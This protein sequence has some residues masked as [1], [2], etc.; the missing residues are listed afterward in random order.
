MFTSFFKDTSDK[1]NARP[2]KLISDTIIT[3]LYK[4]RGIR[5]FDAA[6]RFFLVL[7]YPRSLEES[8]K[9]KR[10]K[11][12][13]KEKY[14]LLGGRN[15]HCI[16]DLVIHSGGVTRV[17][18]LRRRKGYCLRRSGRSPNLGR[19]RRSGPLKM[20]YVCRAECE[21]S[22]TQEPILEYFLVVCSFSSIYVGD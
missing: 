4:D 8:W 21:G 18:T 10:N 17:I 22:M 13:L 11:K 9:L 1:K 2:Q 15:L 7:V 16:F 14:P 19:V 5:R 3:W 6:N 12:L 20:C